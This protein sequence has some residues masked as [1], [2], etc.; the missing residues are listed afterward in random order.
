MI[1]LPDGLVGGEGVAVIMVRRAIDAIKSGDHIYAI[2]R[3]IC[4]NNDG[5]EKS[6]F[7]TPGIKRSKQKL[8]QKY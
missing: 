2:I 4:I 8:L 7:Y 6:G 5:S 1:F 3:G